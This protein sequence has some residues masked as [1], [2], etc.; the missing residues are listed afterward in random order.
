MLICWISLRQLIHTASHDIH[1]ALLDCAKGDLH[2]AC[3][4]LAKDLC[5][6]TMRSA[7]KPLLH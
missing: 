5:S 7:K 4:L 2:Y 1:L 3:L 6:D